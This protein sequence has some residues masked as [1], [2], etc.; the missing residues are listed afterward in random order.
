VAATPV[1]ALQTEAA[2]Q[3]QPWTESTIQEAMQVLRSEFTPISDMRASGDYR[4]TV[5]GNLLQ[6]CWLESQGHAPASIAQW[7]ATH[8]EGAL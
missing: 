6:R 3:G 1:R 5:L 4:R 2:L 8:L 7:H